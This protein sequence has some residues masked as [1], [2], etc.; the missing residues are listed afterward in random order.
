[1]AASLAI[2]G[3]IELFEIAGYFAF[4]FWA[5]KGGGSLVVLLPSLIALAFA[6]VVPSS[7]PTRDTRVTEIVIYGG[8]RTLTQFDEPGSKISLDHAGLLDGAGRSS[9]R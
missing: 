2:F 1:V 9:T 8:H 7:P 5:R 6:S 4:W 3:P